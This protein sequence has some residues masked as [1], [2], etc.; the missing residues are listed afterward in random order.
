MSGKPYQRPPYPM[1]WAR[2]EG[3]GRIFYTAIGDRP[4]NWSSALFLNLLAGGIRW[5]IGDAP[6]TITA[7]LTQVAPGA[8]VI[9]PK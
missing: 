4:E 2:M 5:A 9:P 6:A 8:N 1:T 7:N 3:R